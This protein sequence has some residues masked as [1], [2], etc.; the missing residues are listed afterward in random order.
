MTETPGKLPGQAAAPGSYSLV[1]IQ[2]TSTIDPGDPI[3][4]SLYI[5]GTGTITQNQLF[6]G[7]E[8]PD[9]VGA[10]KGRLETCLVVDDGVVTGDN[11]EDHGA[12]I[13]KDLSEAGGHVSLQTELFEQMAPG[14][15]DSN[16]DVP[17]FSVPYTGTRHNGIPPLRYVLETD[18]DATPGEYDLPIVFLYELD[19]DEQFRERETVSVHVN[20]TRERIEPVPTAAVVIGGITSVLSL[21]YAA[22]GLVW[23][24][25]V[26]ALALVLPFWLVPECRESPY[27]WVRRSG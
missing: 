12:P 13:V 5:T 27:D 20:T 25:V 9:L 6:V 10:N 2:E 1:P 21:V 23:L 4:I 19:G 22:A 16:T 8:H 14:E 3:K 11:A 17:H 7:H 24:S 18:E 26:V 15:F